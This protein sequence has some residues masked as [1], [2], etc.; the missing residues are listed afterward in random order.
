MFQHHC[1]AGS[2]R[3]FCPGSPGRRSSPRAVYGHPGVTGSL[4]ERDDQSK[5]Q[6]AL[7]PL[8]DFTP[9]VPHPLPTPPVSLP[10]CSKAHKTQGNSQNPLHLCVE[11]GMLTCSTALSSTAPVAAAAVVRGASPVHWHADPGLPLCP[12]PSRERES[13]WTADRRPGSP[14][15]QLHVSR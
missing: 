5:S 14:F 6:S 10:M 8:L 2:W 9:R 11:A 15:C 7:L 13:D 4:C 3:P 1:C 12:S